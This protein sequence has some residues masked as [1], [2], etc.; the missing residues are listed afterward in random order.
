MNNNMHLGTS[1]RIA[2]NSRHFYQIPRQP[3][4]EIKYFFNGKKNENVNWS[5]T[6]KTEAEAEK[7]WSL[8]CASLSHA[9]SFTSLASCS[10][11]VR[12]TDRS[13][14]FVSFLR[15]W[16]ENNSFLFCCRLFLFFFFFLERQCLLTVCVRDIDAQI[17][18]SQ[19]KY[20]NNKVHGVERAQ[21]RRATDQCSRYYFITS[22]DQRSATAA[23]AAAVST[24]S[25]ISFACHDSKCAMAAPIAH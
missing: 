9:D 5:R 11:G 18:L 7:M 20:A 1:P 8:L 17:S 4:M 24:I 3:R 19:L 10:L 22:S 13:F 12:S 23:V 16:S 25:M 14:R 6:W 21:R 2:M 15:C